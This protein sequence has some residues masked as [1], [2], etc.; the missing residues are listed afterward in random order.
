MFIQLSKKIGAKVFMYKQEAIETCNRQK[1]GYRYG[2]A[3]KV[4]ANVRKCFIDNLRKY[5][6]D[7]DVFDNCDDSDNKFNYGY[8]YLTEVADIERDY[9]D[10]EFKELA[11]K[12]E[13]HKF[14][15]DDL[16]GRN[17]GWIGRRL[18]CLDWGQLTVT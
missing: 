1:R 4:L 18:V 10:G 2:I 13:R 14:E 11:T 8:F 9:G 3:P 7:N 5:D 12:M 6:D 16:D 17:V 15:I